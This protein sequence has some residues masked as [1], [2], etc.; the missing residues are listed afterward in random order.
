MLEMTAMQTRVALLTVFLCGL[1]SAAVAAPIDYT[2]TVTAPGQIGASAASS[3]VNGF[4]DD[5]I[6][7]ASQ[8]PGVTAWSNSP[9]VGAIWGNSQGDPTVSIDLGKPHVLDSLLI[10]YQTWTGAGVFAWTSV[11]VSI[12]GG[13]PI[14]F[15]SFPGSGNGAVGQKTINLTGNVGQFLNLTFDRQV[16]WGPLSEIDVFGTPTPEASTIFMWLIFG[17]IGSLFIWRRGCKTR[18]QVMAAGR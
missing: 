11:A 2:Y 13:T 8:N 10:D 6:Y 3:G 17:S 9:G 16:E 1:A 5:G 12:D 15:T 4:L 7:T 18:S 14:N